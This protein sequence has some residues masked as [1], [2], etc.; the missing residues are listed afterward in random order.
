DLALFDQLLGISGVG[1]KVALT[2][3]GIGSVE[4]VRRAIMS[5]DLDTL[6]SVPGVGKKTAQK[7]IL[8]LKGQLV[9]LANASPVDQEVIQ[10][11]QGL[12]Y[13]AQQ[14]REAVKELS[15]DSESTSD[16]VR[17]ALRWLAK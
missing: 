5:G 2:I 7:I 16:R 12:G 9:E 14:A 8:E 13:S 11:L 6:T 15:P 1:P 10:A 4:T 3:L 17:E